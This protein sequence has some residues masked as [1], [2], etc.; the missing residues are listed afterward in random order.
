MLRSR[1]LRA[2][3]VAAPGLMLAGFGVV[4]PSDLNVDTAGWWATLHIILLP[5]F[6]LLAA[7]Q[8]HLLTPAAPVVRWLGR[9]AAFGFAAFYTGLDAVAGIGAG[10]VVDAQHGYSRA[11]GR[12][13]AVGDGLGYVGSWSFLAASLLV[14]AAV[15]PHG[16]WRVVP[17]AVLLVAASVSFL[18]SHLF[19]PRGVY[20]MIGIAA[21]MF[22]L[23][24]VS[25][26]QRESGGVSLR[27]HAADD[28]PGVRIA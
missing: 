10:T 14:V 20:T 21:G 3:L 6:A 27:G 4:H 24:Y 1:L 28:G 19:W 7:A 11:V 12:L 8:W 2:F 17:G 16:G 13:F 18:D 5:A 23:S 15:A 26:P 9:L 25:A 22:L